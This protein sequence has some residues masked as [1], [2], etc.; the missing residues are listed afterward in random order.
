MDLISQNGATFRFVTSGW[1]FYLNLAEEYG[2]RPAGTLPPKSYP[3]PAKW[4]GEYDW[5]AGQI[6]SAVD[7]RQLAEALER[8]LADPQRAEREKLLAERL[9]EALRAMTGLDSQIQPPTDDTA[10][11][12][13]VITFFRQGQFEIW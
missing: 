11:L 2:W 8:A 7:P 13:E 4:P 12:K 6:V 1:S 9:A 5:N 3:D 10:F